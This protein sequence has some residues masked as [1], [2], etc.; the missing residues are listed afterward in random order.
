MANRIIVALK[1][2]AKGFYRNKSTMFWTIAFPLLLIL[3]F[4]AIF[5]AS[6]NRYDLYVQDLSDSQA[7]HQFLVALNQTGSVNLKFIDKQANLDQYIKDRSL[8]AV[9]IIPVNFQMTFAPGAGN[10]TT[11][12]I[13]RTDPSQSSS[14]V[15][16]SVVAA[17]ANQANLVMAHGNNVITMGRAD[18]TSSGFKYI[19]FFIPGVIALT[20]MTTTIFWMVSVMTRYRNNGIFK[21]LTT[22]PITR[23]EWLTSQILWQLFVVF[24]SI[25]V[26]MIVGM[27]A[28]NTHMTLNL[29]AIVTI[30]L[31]SALFSS[32]G[33]I[34]ARF[35]KEEEAASAAANA[36]TF[37]MM[38]LAG[39][40]FPLSMFPS[41][42]G[43][44][45]NVLPLTY[46]GNA[47]RDS[48]V[49]GNIGSATN[50]MLVVAG[51]AIVFFIAGIIFSK[52][53]T[54]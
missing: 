30:V 18:I 41:W 21:K 22:T 12:L 46:V 28:F 19:D 34:I 53:R 36:I 13:M 40:F 2:E 1:G 27:L 52:W 43:A 32:M 6:G 50:N 39:I 45:A 33:M 3:L 38:F 9:L 16:F 17:V 26:I 20:T 23:M 42:L 54:E 48:M 14:N 29:V 7:S 5:S 11:Q 24:L 15:V 8:S 31:S 10:N 44:I 25:A 37:P 51:F 35:I 4:G 47:L 49:Y